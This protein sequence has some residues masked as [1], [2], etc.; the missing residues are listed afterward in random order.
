M[1]GSIRAGRTVLRTAVSAECRVTAHDAPQP[2]EIVAQ[3][4]AYPYIHNLLLYSL[5]ILLDAAAASLETSLAGDGAALEVALQVRGQELAREGSGDLA[6][7]VVLGDLDVLRRDTGDLGNGRSLGLEDGLEVLD[8]DLL[9]RVRLGAVVGPLPELQPRDLSGGG[10]F[11]GIVSMKSE[12]RCR[13]M[14]AAGWC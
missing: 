7:H 4:I 5:L 2:S 6:Q 11:L 14:D 3:C 10:V 12:R 13:G 8:V 1:N 9:A